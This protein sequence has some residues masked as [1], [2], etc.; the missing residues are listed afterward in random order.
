VATSLANIR[1]EPHRDSG[2]LDY[3][4]LEGERNALVIEAKRTGT[5]LIDTVKAG[6]FTAQLG[7]A[8]LQSAAD[9]IRQ[10]RSY[11]VDASVGF[12]ALTTGLAW[13]GFRPLRDDGLDPKRG[14]AHIFPTLA[15]IE[16]TNIYA[17]CDETTPCAKLFG[18]NNAL[19]A[20]D[21]SHS[22]GVGTFF[23]NLE[24]GIACASTQ[25]FS[26]AISG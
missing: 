6:Y 19:S 24:D 26:R 7:G 25:Y 22:F 18:R 1:T 20:R 10:T 21:E 17:A 2:F 23:V 11:S 12:A 8:A 14:I 9:G 13:I 3:L 15:S 4:I 5:P 16:R